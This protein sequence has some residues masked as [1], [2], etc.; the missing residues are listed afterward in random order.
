MTGT[1]GPPDNCPANGHL[2]HAPATPPRPGHHGGLCIAT[3]PTVGL[4]PTGPQVT[5]TSVT[6]P[7]APRDAGYDN[8][9]H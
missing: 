9:H 5:N 1:R 8:S 6:E 4:L 7:T 3:W 2:D